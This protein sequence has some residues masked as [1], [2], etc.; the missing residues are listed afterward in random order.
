MD[1][2][3]GRK[4][5]PAASHRLHGADRSGLGE[6]GWAEVPEDRL[7]DPDDTNVGPEFYE[8]L[9]DSEQRRPRSS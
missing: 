8:P 4:Q 5:I 9:S 2:P 7:G 1:T 6:E 3:E